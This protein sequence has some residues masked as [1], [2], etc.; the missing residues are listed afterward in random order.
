MLFLD[1]RVNKGNTNV[2]IIRCRMETV[3]N[4][5]IFNPL[6]RGTSK[7]IETSLSWDNFIPDKSLSAVLTSERLE[8]RSLYLIVSPGCPA[9]NGSF[10][11]TIPPECPNTT[12]PWQCVMFEKKQKQTP[13][14]TPLL[15][16]NKQKPTHFH[17]AVLSV[18]Y[19]FS[20]PEVLQLIDS[21]QF[22]AVSCCSLFTTPETCFTSNI[23]ST[24]QGNI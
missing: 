19:Q 13:L 24:T 8:K 3:L 15:L 21:I 11:Q 2:I 10:Y 6:F 5:K 16:I 7:K 17:P 20:T 22:C 14:F 4:E 9:R 18:K 1:S 23:V 12:S